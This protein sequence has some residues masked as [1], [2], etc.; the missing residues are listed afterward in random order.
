V[1]Y[2]PPA[3]FSTGMSAMSSGPNGFDFAPGPDGPRLISEPGRLATAPKAV[4]SSRW[5]KQT[6]APS[7][8]RASIGGPNQ[9]EMGSFKSVNMSNMVNLFT[10]NFS[11]NIPLLDIGGYP[12]NLYYDGE[13]GP[14]QDASWV[15]LGWNINPGSISRNMRGIPDDFDG[16]DT[17]VQTTNL[18]PNVTYGVSTGADFEYTGI[19]FLPPSLNLTVGVSWNNYLGMAL[20]LGVK[21]G[22]GFKIAD[23]VLSEKGSLSLGASLGGD[24]SSRSGLTL[25]PSTS[26]T[27]G[28][29]SDDRN[30][31]LGSSLSTSYNS[32]QGIKSLQ[33]SEQASANIQN[34]DGNSLPYSEDLHSNAINFA[35]PSYLPT[36]RVPMVN[37]AFSGHFQLGGGIYGAFT[38]AEMEAY[39]QISS[40][41]PSKY[42]Q[43]KPMV[44]YL[45][46][47]NAMDNPNAVTDF[48]RFNDRE[49]TPN[50]PIISAPQ[51]TY[52]VYTIQGEGTGGS[53][54]PYRG[55]LGYVRDN[56]TGSQDRSTG[57]GV[58]I[59]PPGHYG[60]NLN[61][62]KTPTT[63]TEWTAGNTLHSSIPFTPPTTNG[64]WEN[65]CFRNPGEPG[66]LDNNAYTRIGGTD[67][68]RF[69][70]TG[71]PHNPEITTLLDRFSKAGN[72]TGSVNPT[73][74]GAYTRQKRG[75]V[76]DFFNA[77]DATLVGLDKKIRSYNNHMLL[78][79][80]A[81]TLLYTAMARDSGYRK[82]HHISQINVTES[83]GKRYIYGLPVYNVVQRDYTF[84]V[85]NS[86][87]STPDQS[88]TV[89]YDPSERNPAY[90]STDSRDGYVQVTQTPAY[91][92][93]FLLTGLLSPDYVDVTGDGITDDDLGQAVKFNYTEIVDQY[94]NPVLHQWRTP[95]GAGI[96]NFN[97]GTRSQVK[98][99]KGL[100]SYGE[101]ESW[102]LH[103]IETKTMIA[104][105]TLENRCDG[106][107]VTGVDSGVNSLDTS[108]RALKQIDLYSKSDLRQNGLAGAHPIKTVHFAY[109]Y[110]LCRGTRDN[111]NGQG[112]L[113]LDSVWFTFNRQ[114]RLN[115]DKYAFS[116]LDTA[117]FIDPV[118]LQPAVD[119]FGNPAYVSHASDRWGTYK[120]QS[121]NPG[122]VKNSDFPYTPQ[123]QAGQRQSPKAALDTNAA[124]WSLKRILLPSGG[125][126]EIGYE[127]DDY[128]YVQNLHA[129]DMFT[130]AGFGSTPTAYSNRLFDISWSGIV[131][132][133]YLFVKVPFAG[134]TAGDVLQQYLLGDSMLAVK[135]DVT[136]PTGNE[137]IT[138]YAKFDT[139]G[140]YDSA[141]IWI[142]LINVNNV[143]P[144]SLTAVEYL[145][146]QLPAEA[147][148]GYDNSRGGGL[149]QVGDALIGLLDNL[150]HA[151]SDPVSYL[152]GQG[153]AQ[154]TVVGQC[155]ARLNDPVG[156]KYGG[157][158]RVKFIKLKDNWQKMTGQYNSTYTQ[159]YDYTTTET[160]NGATRTI[161]SGV[162]AYE[163]GIGGDENPFQ[164]IV[165]I[166]DKLPLGPT[167]YGAIEMPILEPFFPAPTV[168]Y[169]QVTVRSVSSIP[170]GAQQ[171]SRSGIGRQV[172]QFYTAKD[173]PVYYSNTWLDPSTDLEAHDGSTTNF[174]HKY[175]FDSRALSQ[176]FLVA[177]N[178]MHGK[179][180]SQTSYAD[181]DTT[182]K[183]NYTENFYRNTGVNG[184]NETFPFVS[185]AQ[186]GTISQGNL[187]IDIELMTDTREFTVQSS[188]EE[189]QAQADYFPPFFWPVFIWPV[190][191]SSENDYRAVTTTKV[192]G[193]HAV[194]DSVVVYDKGSMVSTRNL[195]YDAET[196]EVVVTR[197][198]NEFDQ[199]LYSTSYPA[200]W[201]YDGMGPAYRNIGYR[202][203]DTPALNFTN[204]I[205]M[206]PQ[207]DVCQLVSG[208]ELLVTSPNPR[209]SCPQ[210]SAPVSKLWVLD[211]NKNNSPFPAT[212]PSFIFID[213]AGNPY[214]NT[215]VIRLRVIRSGRRNM[216]DEKA[217]T[218][219]S[220]NS[221]IVTSNGVQSLHLDSTSSVLTATA[222][223][224]GEKW[225]TDQDEIRR[226]TPVYNAAT[227][228]YI[229][230]Q[231]CTGTLENINPYVKGLLG[232]FRNFRTMVCYGPRTEADPTQPTNLPKN[233]FIANFSP[234][235]SFGSSGLQPNTGSPLWIESV[236]TT[237]VN[238]QGLELE[239]K[240][241]LGIYTSAQYGYDKTLPIAVTNNS[242]YYEMAYEGFEDNA[243]AQSIDN[244]NADPCPLRQ[245]N[246]IGMPN[247][248]LVFTDTTG[249]AAHTGKYVLGVNGNSTAS[250]SIPIISADNYNYTF[251]F[252]SDTSRSF[253]SPGVNVSFL[254]SNP[255]GVTSAA[256]V[257]YSPTTT[258]ILPNSYS[259]TTVTGEQW[260]CYIQIF[261][262]GT[263]TFSATVEAFT[264]PETGKVNSQTVNI[265]D[266]SGTQFGYIS[267]S[268]NQTGGNE[269]S[270]SSISVALCPGIYHIQGQCSDGVN[271]L[272]HS[273]DA[274]D[275]EYT[276]TCSNC[277]SQLYTGLTTQN[278][279]I[280][281]TPIAGST[282]MENPV[283][284]MPAGV[285]MVVSAWVRESPPVASSG[286]D[287]TT[288]Y[289]HGYITVYT[290]TKDTTFYPQGPIIDGW[291]RIEG[292]FTPAASGTAKISF[293]NSTGNMN[294]FD[295][296]RIHPFNAEM[297]SY[298]YDPVS[299]RLSAE[300]DDNNYA[301]FYEYDEEGTLVRTKAETQRGIQTIK[302]TRSAKQKNITTIQ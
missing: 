19:K 190:T 236:R 285:P 250:L 266:L 109:S 229:P 140:V 187:G 62:I 156:F 257:S 283:F 110:T 125:Q 63:I 169:S 47:E 130:V 278:G 280:S 135:L 291:Q 251:S 248:Q 133:N 157:G 106:K 247:S 198:N 72:F 168:G 208:D 231:N 256:S 244:T 296:I 212:T 263:Y 202:Y 69:E 33:I 53:I 241:A 173:F 46:Y 26:L 17:L 258:S 195:L 252:G 138:S 100:I 95:A 217:A 222:A 107:G 11:Y 210:A 223:E 61:L 262:Q 299:L 240:N 60:A 249:F 39:E 237:R 5:I 185:A 295:D 49:V 15:G 81:D 260:D 42:M 271:A 128:A 132:N 181:N 276:W 204:G 9:P 158:Q 37:S 139:Y 82:G 92:H 294:Y 189:I 32:R 147:F 215:N 270:S 297:K 197:T 238:A 180:R 155:F 154:S 36:I 160:F 119:T 50:T 16:T 124:A 89:T 199:P 201:A 150:E 300:L 170:P 114:T 246:F 279:C 213:S 136:M 76:I 131:E 120:P 281:T 159:T 80:S 111:T 191:A 14:E 68:V 153:K 8:A 27:A 265:T 227:C 10:G 176:G 302:E 288:A 182:L 233:G 86:N 123:N 274:A 144:L 148:P 44:G 56:Y 301:T 225:Q 25:S 84:T 196:G 99:D 218:V 226:F 117:T 90:A 242:P 172:T 48:T 74:P 230:V 20:D 104:V 245:A 174:F 41:D 121:M 1:F 165:Q 64:S 77:D 293:S 175:A 177:V 232:N 83:N 70:V 137:R 298:I 40:I 102:Y 224:Y 282:T 162:A 73:G 188:G 97:P 59:G 18:K 3:V 146:E 67:L 259:S 277:T 126:L 284:S 93:S 267:V 22:V 220:M 275:D 216:L 23:K 129:M 29:Y 268:H 94:G 96:A 55:D 101:R 207:F 4:H 193:Y 192:I 286:A 12:V 214:T 292:Y 79:P 254:P 234:Y 141:T 75:Q 184:L 134:K 142:H 194:L 7:P 38:S 243:Y 235:W 45:Y 269:Y 219:T 261:T 58:D 85:H 112:R 35:R 24:L 272:F 13:V 91:A 88:D 211:L 122:G 66:V 51:Y 200:W 65:V 113:T 264:D 206:S 118:T 255:S 52:D 34:A 30:F 183:V 253:T 186:G 145:K 87:V 273:T 71:D 152:R 105:F 31:T 103:S 178:D 163:P 221:P 203:S 239:T 209:G 78:D 54:R 98:D 164:T 287:T 179:M 290:G 228:S 161:S 28:F 166:Q 57:V 167:S 115:K 205:L 43:Y 171:K 21:G 289:S 127:S 143:G 108:S 6:T 116:Y 149:E 2:R 151:F